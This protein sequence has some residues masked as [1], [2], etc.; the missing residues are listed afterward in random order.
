[1]PKKEDIAVNRT[2]ALILAAGLSSRMGRFK[3]LL[4]LGGTSVLGR[5]VGL[6]QQAGVADVRVVAGH[7]ADDLIP[8]I[9]ALGAKAV[10]NPDYE[11]GM[12][13]S[14]LA[15][16]RSLGP[17]VE[18]FF[19]LPADMPLVRPATV[20]LVL[21][22]W[23]NDPGLIVRPA[24][25]GRRGHPPLIPTLFSTGIMAW[26]GQR[27]LKGAMEQ[28]ED[29]SVTLE[30]DDQGIVLDLD[31]PGDYEQALTLVGGGPAPND[32]A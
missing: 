5:A 9:E 21:E 6:F 13:T 2:A 24:F 32:R 7:R 17:E 23:L 4:P 31:R 11:D 30:I 16:V 26:P 22:R 18:A 1:M 10:I 8:Q 14:V 27:G 19:I 25:Q 28:W 29:R 12:F 3:P 15:G 20:R